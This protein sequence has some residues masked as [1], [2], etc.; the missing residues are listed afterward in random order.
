MNENESS[1]HEN[2]NPPASKNIPLVEGLD[3]YIDSDGY[4]VFTAS[5]LLKRGTCCGNF[6]KHC[7]YPK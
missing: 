2:Q 4:Y 5:Y 3:F 7:P 6:C 1:Q